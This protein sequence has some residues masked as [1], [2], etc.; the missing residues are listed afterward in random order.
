M[1]RRGR[2]RGGTDLACPPQP[3]GL[4]D[5]GATDADLGRAG[6]CPP[7]PLGRVPDLGHRLQ[8]RPDHSHDVPD[9]HGGQLSV[10]VKKNNW[11]ITKF[12]PPIPI[13]S[14]CPDLDILQNFKFLIY[15]FCILSK[16]QTKAKH[17]NAG[18]CPEPVCD[19]L[20]SLSLSCFSLCYHTVAFARHQ[21]KKNHFLL[22]LSLKIKFMN[23]KLDRWRNILGYFLM[24]ARM[25][26]LHHHLQ[27]RKFHNVCNFVTLQ[28]N[29][30]QIKV[31]IFTSTINVESLCQQFNFQFQL[32]V[33]QAQNYI[34]GKKGNHW[35]TFSWIKLQL[36]T[37]DVESPILKCNYL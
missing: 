32:Y 17:C 30:C 18:P 24:E 36:S 31:S 2:G 13:I 11:W 20:G 12:H 6:P 10:K 8:R 9:S 22:A 33:R 27:W 1:G 4:S 14:G 37:S 25:S 19:V 5:L 3:H 16:L 7:H 21:G 35:K 15:I 23:L 26:S 29:Y 34:K 28:I